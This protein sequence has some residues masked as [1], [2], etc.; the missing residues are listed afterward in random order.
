MAGTLA[1]D[2]ATYEA[3]PVAQRSAKQ[4]AAL[5]TDL[6]TQARQ[7]GTPGVAVAGVPT[8]SGLEAD[9]Q[10][11]QGS[12]DLGQ[13]TANTPSTSLFT[14]L[15][16]WVNDLAP[17]VSQA[18]NDL[19]SLAGGVQTNFGNGVALL[20][21][22][23]GTAAVD[24]A[25]AQAG[26]QV[27][28]VTG[29]LV[30][31]AS[32]FVGSAAGQTTA[33]AGGGVGS[34]AAALG[35]GIAQGAE[36]A[37]PGVTSA[38]VAVTDAAGQIIGYIGVNELS[39]AGTAVGTAAAGVG[40]GAGQ[41]ALNAAPGVTSGVSSAAVGAGKAVGQVAAGS[42]AAVGTA[43]GAAASGVG[44][45]VAS[46]ASAAGPGVGSGVA[47]AVSGV[48]SGIGGALSGAGISTSGLLIGGGILLL[49]LFLL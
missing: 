49:L 32:T 37:T 2:I 43:V 41:G 35:T 44:S 45:G 47:S 6:A 26:K 40:Q 20:T 9:R 14:G 28:Q 38:A 5:T 24:T 1:Q 33:S 21:S 46:A 31:A 23:G 27:G 15:G 18:L 13:S 34:G 3:I 7:S 36:A 19:A 30:G 4:S 39:A 25:A 22:P 10:P 12:V 11:V 16:S 42:G 48:A 29:G 17:G 8:S